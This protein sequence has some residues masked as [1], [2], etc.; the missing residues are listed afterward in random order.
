MFF[1]ILQVLTPEQ[2]EQAEKSEYNFD[3]SDAFDWKLACKT[4]KNL[5]NG[6]SAKVIQNNM[7]HMDSGYFFSFV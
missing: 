7:F 4:L 6:K 3:H 1:L 5:K 2:H